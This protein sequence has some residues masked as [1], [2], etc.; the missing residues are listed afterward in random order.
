MSSKY[1]RAFEAFN[2]E[3]RRIETEEE[4][5]PSPPNDQAAAETSARE[6]LDL[7]TTAFQELNQLQAILKR[8]LDAA[9]Q[10]ERPI[11]TEG[12]NAALRA[13]KALNEYVRNCLGSN[14]DVRVI[15]ELARSAKHLQILDTD[16]LTLQ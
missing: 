2:D 16:S 14:V 6:R 13:T 7:L 8:G 4:G 10:G 9:N 15:I 5:K 11:L 3:L 12:R 1:D